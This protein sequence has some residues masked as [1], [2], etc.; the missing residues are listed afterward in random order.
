MQIL[1]EGQQLRGC[2]C[3]VCLLAL[4]DISIFAFVAYALLGNKRG[5]DGDLL[6]GVQNREHPYAFE[7]YHFRCVS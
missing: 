5:G 3:I 4:A 1:K 6:C 2:C 7:F